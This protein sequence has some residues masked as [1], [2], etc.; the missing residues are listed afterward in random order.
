MANVLVWGVL[1]LIVVGVVAFWQY[2][3]S[4]DPRYNGTATSTPVARGIPINQLTG[5]DWATLS[6]SDRQSIIDTTLQ[7]IHCP[8]SITSNDLAIGVT[9]AANTTAGR[10]QKVID[11]LAVLF[12]LDGCVTG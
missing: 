6:F 5:A 2:A 10:S 12:L 3:K 4:Q 11:L 7:R 1:T 9:Q 8:S